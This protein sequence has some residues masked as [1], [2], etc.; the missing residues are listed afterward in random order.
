M[1]AFKKEN[2]LN[3]ISYIIR[4]DVLVQGRTVASFPVVGQHVAFWTG[5]KV[6]AQRVETRVRATA[7]VRP[8][9]VD[10]LARMSVSSQLRSRHIIAAAVVRAVRVVTSSLARTV[11]VA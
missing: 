3:L 11:P 1:S 7:I 9:F 8:A 2:E 5:T 10:I 6:G 4:T